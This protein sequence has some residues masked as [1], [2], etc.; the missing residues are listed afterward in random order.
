M[1]ECSTKADAMVTTL[2][3]TVTPPLLA[4]G[5]P[6]W[7]H[8]MEGVGVPDTAHV[9]MIAVPVRTSLLSLGALVMAAGPREGRGGR[10]GSLE[11]ENILMFITKYSS[12]TFQL[13]MCCL[14]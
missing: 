6:L 13:Q 9:N 14:C 3:A 4:S 12:L 1:P 11:E 8:V 2:P 10:G 7:Y 5:S